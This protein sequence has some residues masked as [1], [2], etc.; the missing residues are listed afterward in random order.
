MPGVHRSTRGLAARGGR[1]ARRWLGLLALPVLAACQDNEPAIA[2]GDRLWA[3]SSYA[4]AR[5]EYRLAVAQRGD[6]EALLRLAHAYARTGDLGQTLETY[7]ALLDRD[8]LYADQA[9]VD[10]LGLARRALD[11]GDEAGAAMAVD[12]ALRIRP[13]IQ[14]PQ[15]DLPLARH[16]AERGDPERALTYYQRALTAM[17][18]DSTPRLLYEMGLLE[19]NR[20]RCERATELFRGFREQARQAGSNEYRGRWRSLVTESRWHL[21]NC[22]FELARESR[23]R[24]NVTQVLAHLETVISLGEPENLLDQAWFDR[25]ETLYA[26]GRFEEALASYRTVLERNP[27]RTGQLVERA[28][29]RIDEIRFGAGIQDS[30]GPR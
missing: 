11:R 13:V 20:G 28:R 23:E 12:A 21:G 17:P 2:R 1:R 7:E 15:L 9:V 29:K 22:A 3:D 4:D 6:E 25:G 14:L 24:G 18:A 8:P 5:A 30:L 26:L 27:S 19:E 10:F 16:Y